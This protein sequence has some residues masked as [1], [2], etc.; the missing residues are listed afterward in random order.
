[1]GRQMEE[2]RKNLDELMSRPAIAKALSG[3]DIMALA[4]IGTHPEDLISLIPDSEVA[5][6]YFLATQCSQGVVFEPTADHMYWHAVA[7][8]L[9]Q[10]NRRD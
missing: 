7:R 2:R 6:A 3:L 1:M 9:L 8:L 5:D 10:R 4:D